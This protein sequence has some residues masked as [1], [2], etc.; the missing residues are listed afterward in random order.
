VHDWEDLQGAF[1]AALR[2]RVGELPYRSWFHDLRVVRLEKGELVLS[3]SDFFRRRRLLGPERPHLEEAASEVLGVRVRLSLRLL[4]PLPSGGAGRPAAGRLREFLVDDANLMAHASVQRVLRDPGGPLNPLVLH[5]PGGA[6]KTL[7]LETLRSAWPADR[8]GVVRWTAEELVRSVTLAARRGQWRAFDPVGGAGLVLLDELHRLTGRKGTQRA[9][10][11]FLGHGL[12]SG[13][14]FVIASRHHPG[15]L[16]AFLPRL[17]SLLLQGMVVE[18]RA[19]RPATVLRA[20]QRGRS[21]AVPEDAAKVALRLAG[22]TIEGARRLLEDAE[23]EAGAA[24]VALDAPFVEG[25]FV[26][27]R[28]TPV[29]RAALAEELVAGAL[30]VPVAGLRGRSRARSLLRARCVAMF[31]LRETLGLSYADLGRRFGGLRGPAAAAQARRGRE[32]VERARLGDVVARVR[33]AVGGA[34]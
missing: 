24:G 1:H 30:A 14:Q 22:G 26:A 5:G 12:E 11:R 20:V 25:L 10:E 31:V 7:L 28:E 33:E 2:R 29:D 6:G 16:R 21:R 17:R 8:A 9:V 23:A 4:P 18:V 19:P 13:R 15:T 34:S 27:P 32:E 3:I